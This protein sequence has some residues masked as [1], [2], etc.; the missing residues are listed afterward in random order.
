MEIQN[1]RK[2]VINQTSEETYKIASM[3]ML[4]IRAGTT[5][6]WF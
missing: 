2:Q 4:R 5:R 3:I 6:S 1:N